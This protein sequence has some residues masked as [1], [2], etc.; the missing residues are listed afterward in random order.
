MTVL[1]AYASA[2]GST[3]DIAARIAAQLREG[4]FGVHLAPVEEVDDVQRHE[5]VVLGSAIHDQAWL[6]PAVAFVRRHAPALAT[7]PLWLFSVGM[8]KALGRALQAAAAREESTLLAALPAA[9]RP[10]AH[11]LFSGV[12]RAEDLPWPG[13][14]FFRALGG[15]YGDFRHW[16]EIDA[17]AGSIGREVAALREPAT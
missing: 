8:P 2:H 13:R 1:V 9:I 17:W 11:R 12:V 14:I 3:R 4:G 10:R 5:A 15:R 6:A 16:A 7:R